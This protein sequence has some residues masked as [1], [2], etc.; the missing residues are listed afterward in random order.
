MGTG[1][2]TMV[3]FEIPSISQTLQN[4]SIIGDKNTIK[5]GENYTVSFKLENGK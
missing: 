2:H 3:I 4:L 5:I 1:Q